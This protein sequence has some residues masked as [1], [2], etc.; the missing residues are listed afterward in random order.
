MNAPPA[1]CPLA[2]VDCDEPAPV[3]RFRHGKHRDR[4]S[5]ARLVTSRNDAARD[6]HSTHRTEIS[7]D[8][9]KEIPTNELTQLAEQFHV[10]TVRMYEELCTRRAAERGTAEVEARLREQD[11]SAA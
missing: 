5:R 11:G 10:L 8:R 7:V 3:I 1:L 9:L 2:E 4:G 6:R